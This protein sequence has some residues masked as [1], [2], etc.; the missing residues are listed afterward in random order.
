MPERSDPPE[1]HP[2]GRWPSPLAA[3][4]VASGRISYSDLQTD[5]TAVYWLESRPAEGGRVVL[6]RMAD[7][8]KTDHSPEDVSIRSRVH[9]YGGGAVCLLP[10]HGHGHGDGAFAY[11]DQRDQVVRFCHGP[12]DATPRA[13]SAAAPDGT[14]WHHGG[15]TASPDG[16]WVLA[17]REA[18]HADQHLDEPARTPVPRRSIVALAVDAG[19]PAETTLLSG[20]DFYGAAAVHPDGDRVVATAWDHPDM[21]WDSSLVIVAALRTDP[22]ATPPRLEVEGEPWVVMPVVPANRQSQPAWRPD[23]TL[24]FVSDRTG[25]WLPYLHSGRPGPEA[26]R[27]LTDRQAEFH[28]PDWGTRAAHHGRPA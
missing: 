26:P 2:Y 7:D 12:G 14:T 1:V 5:G 11:V 18:H 22:A 19:T 17:V 25:W 10:G 21:P 15:L 6:V 28:G 3:S 8:Q 20:H 13:V 9:E 16:A 4:E 24:R 27:P 23:G